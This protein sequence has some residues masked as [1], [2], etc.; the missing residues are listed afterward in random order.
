MSVKRLFSEL[1]IYG[2][3][4]LNAGMLFMQVLPVSDKESDRCKKEFNLMLDS[5]QHNFDLFKFSIKS[6]ESNQVE[7]AIEWFILQLRA[8]VPCTGESAI[9]AT[10]SVIKVI[11]ATAVKSR[12]EEIIEN[13]FFQLRNTTKFI[14]DKLQ[15]SI[16]L[17][18]NSFQVL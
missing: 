12:L 2:T 1:E 9:N 15:N 14:F 8:P 4:K 5:L 6:S 18:A 10:P 3:L 17:L 11:C 13:I 7:D 16:I